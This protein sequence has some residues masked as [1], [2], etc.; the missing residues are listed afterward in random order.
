MEGM[1]IRLQN[2]RKSFGRTEAVAGVDLEIADGEFFSMLGPSGSGKTTVLR[3]IAGFEAPT[4]GTIELAGSD[5]TRLAPFERDVHTVFQDYA[6]FP[7]MTLEQNVAYGLKVRKVPKAERLKQAGEALASVRLADFGSRRPSQLS[8]G[9]RQRVALARALVGRPKV[10]LLDEPLGALDLKLREQ[11]Q[12]EL[13]AI[14]REVGITF[15]FV[16]HDQE[17]ALTMSDRIAVFNQGRVEQIG[18][19]AQIYER[20][21]TPFVAGFVGTSNLLT[22]DAAEQ[23]VGDRGTYSIRPEKIRV[24]KESAIADEPQHSSATGTVAEIVYLGDATRFLVDLD[25]GGRLTALQQNLETSSEDVAAFRG[26]RV[27]LQWHR[28]HNFQVPEAR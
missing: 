4:S 7:H 16:T 28:R 14:Q 11:M 22:D 3:M 21:A 2:L 26:S 25:A 13:K 17:E 20:P 23:V 8:G 6:L 10:L 24:L 12:V 15:V 19:P 27:T 18:T 1:A 5:V 9:Q